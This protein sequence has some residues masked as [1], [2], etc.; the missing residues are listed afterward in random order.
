MKKIL[1]L[2]LIALVFV[3]FTQIVDSKGKSSIPSVDIKNLKKEKVNTAK[4]S[5][6]GK[7]FVINFWATWCKPCVLELNTIA[8]EY[9]DWVE[10]TGVKLYA[11]S[12]DDARNSKRVASF[13]KGRRW[14][15]EVLLDENSDFK[16]AMNVNNP[17]HTFLYD[18]DGKLVWQH[19]GYAPGDEEELY[20]E[21]LKLTKK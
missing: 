1:H 12:I 7:P 18:G 13:V 10:E 3:A 9:P 14:E 2:T 6:D 11:V 4:L 17:P 15:Y 20:E 16:R 5:N 8:D 21:I 19:N